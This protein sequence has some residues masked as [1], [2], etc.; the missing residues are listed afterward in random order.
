[1]SNYKNPPNQTICKHVGKIRGV[2]ELPVLLF[3]LGTLL[4]ALSLGATVAKISL[5]KKDN[6]TVHYETENNNMFFTKVIVIGALALCG[7]ILGFISL[8]WGTA[9]IIRLYN[10]VRPCCSCAKEFQFNEC[11]PSL[12]KP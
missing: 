2:Y 3:V 1:M 12:D 9:D 10:K 11:L 7:Q 5:M 4:V 6:L 8:L